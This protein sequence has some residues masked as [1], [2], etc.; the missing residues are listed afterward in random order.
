MM[1]RMVVDLENY[2]VSVERL[3]EYTDCPQEAPAVVPGNRPQ[4]SWPQHGRV[5][6]HK[7]STRYRPGLDLV[8]RQIACEINPGEKV[9]GR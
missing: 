7:Y 1:V 4:R 8:L 6:F 5:A 3:Q 9:R 2:I